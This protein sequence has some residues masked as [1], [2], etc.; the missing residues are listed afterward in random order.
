MTVL[1]PLEQAAAVV[2]Q[3]MY[4]GEF[5]QQAYEGLVGLLIGRLEPL[6]FGSFGLMIV[7][8]E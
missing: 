2:Q 6:V 7:R 3:R 4:A 8:A 1:H 5:I